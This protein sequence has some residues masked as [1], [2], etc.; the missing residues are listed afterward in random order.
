MN[1]EHYLVVHIRWSKKSCYN[2]RK[3][4]YIDLPDVFWCDNEDS[5]FAFTIFP[6]TCDLTPNFSNIGNVEYIVHS[7]VSN[8]VHQNLTVTQSG[9]V[10]GL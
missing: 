3:R 1:D 4:F 2:Y 10:V 6:I 9:E 5:K 7:K 8:Q